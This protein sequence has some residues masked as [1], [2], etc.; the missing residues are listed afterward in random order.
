MYLQSE[1]REKSWEC[2][3]ERIV[4][5]LQ[6]DTGLLVYWSMVYVDLL[7]TRLCLCILYTLCCCFSAA[8]KNQ[9]VYAR[10]YTVSQ[11][12]VS[13]LTGYSF[14]IRPP[15]FII[16]GTCHQQTFKNQQQV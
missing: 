10:L 8:E 5:V 16:F 15:M 9:R 12:S 6:V 4:N 7:P 2:E 3:P 1:L 13:A 11:K 14:N